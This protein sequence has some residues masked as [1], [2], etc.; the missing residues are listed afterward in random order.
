MRTAYPALVTVQPAAPARH[1]R[2][3]PQGEKCDSC[4]IECNGTD[5]PLA[6]GT[7]SVDVIRM[8]CGK[9]C[10]GDIVCAHAERAECPSICPYFRLTKVC[11]EPED[12]LAN[13]YTRGMEIPIDGGLMGLVQCMADQRGCNL[14]EMVNDLLQ[15]AIGHA[16]IVTLSME[17][18]RGYEMDGRTVV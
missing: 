2:R 4:D 6:P 1:V 17:I 3:S 16:H 5:C 10:I 8:V 13:E 7:S 9:H 15:E 18:P 12:A 11:N 14:V